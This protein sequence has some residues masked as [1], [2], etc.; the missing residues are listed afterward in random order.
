M[1]AKTGKPAILKNWSKWLLLLLLPA[2]G[3]KEKPVETRAAFYHWKTEVTLGPADSLK[4]D[5]LGVTR[6]YTRFF[7]IDQYGSKL[8]PLG[9]VEWTELPP[10]HLEIVPCVYITNRAM[11]F[12]PDTAVQSLALHI[13][14][15]IHR[16]LEAI[17]NKVPEVQMDCDWTEES[18]D[19]YFLLLRILGDLFHNEGIQVSATIRLHQVKYRERTGVPPTDRGMLMYYNMGQLDSPTEKN[20]ILNLETANLYL[21]RL[22]EYPLE[23][24][25]ALPL[26]SWAVQF[27]NG[28][29]FRL[30]SAWNRSDFETDSLFV[31]EGENTFVVSRNAL[32]KGEYLLEGDRFRIEEGT[33]DLNMEA[34]RK[35]SVTWRTKPLY[36]SLFHYNPY[37]IEH[38][39]CKRLQDIYRTAAR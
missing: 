22:P 17:P 11:R 23:L 25:L 26:F 31:P 30:H 6:L 8:K 19:R 33:P 35:L 1:C 20:S 38:Y 16:L 37:E 34:I 4:L 27:R 39:S 9:V 10:A 5:S 12:I 2:C 36:L 7:D 24:D 28:E 3:P 18:R 13:H 21:E 32:F 15:K 29:F 14:T